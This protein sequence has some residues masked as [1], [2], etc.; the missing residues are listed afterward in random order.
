MAMTD[1]Q[2]A[3]VRDLLE[4]V[5]RTVE[6]NPGATAPTVRMRAKLSRRTGDKALELLLRSGFLER[7]RVDAQD[8]Y[9]SVR[10]Y[11]VSNEAPRA[12]YGDTHGR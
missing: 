11:R 6:T 12:A 9:R 8:T 2:H 7:R 4:L 5:S 3:K 10:P 1:A